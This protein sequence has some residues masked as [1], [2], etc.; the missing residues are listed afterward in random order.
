MREPLG[1]TSG[2]A[3]HLATQNP[4][5]S[6][7]TLQI[8]L[9]AGASVNAQNIYGQTPLVGALVDVFYDYHSNIKTHTELLIDSG[10]DLS[11]QDVRGWSPLHYSCQR[12]NMNSMRALLMAG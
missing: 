6:A 4:H 12:G 8:L 1:A 2:T 3:L 7:D 10:A 9:S 11:L 5:L